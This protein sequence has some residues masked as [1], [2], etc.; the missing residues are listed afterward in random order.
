MLDEQSEGKLEAQCWIC[1]ICYDDHKQNDTRAY[2]K[3]LDLEILSDD[4]ERYKMALESIAKNSCCD[5][6]QEAKLVAI[7]A[8]KDNK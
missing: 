5:T 4:R 6:C 1:P 8:L 2:C 3:V 7:N